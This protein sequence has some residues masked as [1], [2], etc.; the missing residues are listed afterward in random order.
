[1]GVED[2]RQ[3]LQ[4]NLWGRI[5]SDLTVTLQRPD[6]STEELA[7]LKAQLE[8]LQ[9]VHLR[10]TLR[11]E[12]YVIL[13]LTRWPLTHEIMC[14]L[15]GLPQW[16]SVLDLSQC[17]WPLAHTEYT[18]L[19]QHL[20]SSYVGWVLPGKPKSPLLESIAQGI[21]QSKARLGPGPTVLLLRGCSGGTVRVGEHALLINKFDKDTLQHEGVEKLWAD[22]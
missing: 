5:Q 16:A 8:V 20:P 11:T 19:A 14:E 9:G 18:A 3:R 15:Q 22:A 21:A 10:D 13:Q 1:M 6:N 4:H 12:K 7:T 17:E 2:V